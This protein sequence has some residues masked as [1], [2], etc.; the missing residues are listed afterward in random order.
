MSGYVENKRKKTHLIPSLQKFVLP[1]AQ[2]RVF[3]LCD[4]FLRD[5]V[6]V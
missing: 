2:V 1:S 4:I 6:P 5:I 3:L